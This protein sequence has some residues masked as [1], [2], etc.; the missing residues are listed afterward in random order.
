MR[1]NWKSAC[2]Q[3][4]QSRLRG[5]EINIC[6]GLVIANEGREGLGGGGGTHLQCGSFLLETCGFFCLWKFVEFSANKIVWFQFE[7]ALTSVTQ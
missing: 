1:F 3:L 4:E 6:S 7:I 2:I 5:M